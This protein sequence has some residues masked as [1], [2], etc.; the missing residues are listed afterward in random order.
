MWVDGGDHASIGDLAVGGN[1]ELGNVEYIVVAVRH[2]IA[3]V[4]CEATDI[5]GQDGAP[6]RLVGDLEKLEQ[7]HGL[8]SDL[9]DH[10]IGLFLEYE[11]MYSINIAGF[12]AGVAT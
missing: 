4:L 5:V 2:A 3:Y 10:R 1:S 8:A 9:I 6:D 7:I 11:V 12:D